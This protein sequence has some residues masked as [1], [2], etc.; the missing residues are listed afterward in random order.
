MDLTKSNVAVVIILAALVVR[1]TDSFPIELNGFEAKDDAS[2]ETKAYVSDVQELVSIVNASFPAALLGD[3]SPPE[4]YKQKMKNATKNVDLITHILSSSSSVS[5]SLKR[6]A[7][8][9]AATSCPVTWVVDFASDRIPSHFQKA[10]CN[11]PGTT[12]LSRAGQPSCEEISVVKKVYK[13]LGMTPDYKKQIWQIRHISI[14]IA[15]SCSAV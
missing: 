14:P 8:R 6:R 10:T 9:S 4:Y 5:S 12:C 13:F 2:E 3:V 7:R 11:Q 1:M 15:C